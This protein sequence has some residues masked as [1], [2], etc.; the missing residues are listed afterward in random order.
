[1]GETLANWTTRVRHLLRDSNSVDLTDT[2]ILESGIKP[3]LAQYAIDRPRITAVDLAPSTRYLALPSSGQGWIDGFSRI[4][5]IEAPAGE[6]P[7]VVLGYDTWTFTRDTAT[8]T[9]IKVL[10]PSE[11][12]AGDTARVIFT[13]SWPLPTGT[14]GDDLVSSVAFNAVT[15]LAAAMAASALAAEASRSRQGS[16]ATNFVDG[17]DRA[18]RLLELA[19]SLRIIYNTFIG[20]GSA[21]APGV[22]DGASSSKRLQSIQLVR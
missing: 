15:S 10:L 4:Q 20:L 14:A 12:A 17:T 7:A 2:Q 21:G 19:A 5:S 1:M 6:T 8:A 13:T 22:P 11:L 18:E 16:L 9:T 3:A